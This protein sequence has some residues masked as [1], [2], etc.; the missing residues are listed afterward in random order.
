M[1]S[2]KPTIE[3]TSKYF[4]KH[5][6]FNK[7]KD[8]WIVTT[9]NAISYHNKKLINI[10]NNINY[11]FSIGPNNNHKILYIGLYVFWTFLE[12]SLQL[13]HNIACLT[14]SNISEKIDISEDIYK[15]ILQHGIN[16]VN[17]KLPVAFSGIKLTA[18]FSTIASEELNY[19]SYNIKNGHI[20][21][22]PFGLIP[23]LVIYDIFDKQS[24]KKLQK[25]EIWINKDEEKI[26][27]TLHSINS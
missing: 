17:E 20:E 10:I 13:K 19:I 4:S 14:E 2:M 27:N 15:D 11:I 18:L 16:M 9:I 22:Y 7:N 21:T 25:E 23:Y 3:E 24:R 1:F 12:T 8:E 6:I 5:P 26:I